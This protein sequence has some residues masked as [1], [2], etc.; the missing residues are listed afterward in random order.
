ML[1]D[2]QTKTA[3]SIILYACLYSISII[4]VSKPKE[5]L[6]T[7]FI[8]QLSQIICGILQS[9]RLCAFKPFFRVEWLFDA[10]V[11]LYGHAVTQNFVFVVSQSEATKN[12]T[13][14]YLIRHAKQTIVKKN[15]M[16][17]RTNVHY[18]AYISD[19]LSEICNTQ[20]ITFGDQTHFFAHFTFKLHLAWN[21]FDCLL[22]V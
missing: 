3:V 10:K 8:S 19:C 21:A 20:T 15:L 7:Q 2:F 17:F 9:C 14:D 12:N 4:C 16:Q 18:M 6:K 13:H 5:S 11:M 1:F 22:W